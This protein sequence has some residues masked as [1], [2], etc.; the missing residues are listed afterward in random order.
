MAAIFKEEKSKLSLSFLEGCRGF[1]KDALKRKISSLPRV[2]LYGAGPP[3]QGLSIAGKK[4]GIEPC[5]NS[6]DN[7]GVFFDWV[8]TIINAFKLRPT[9]GQ[10]A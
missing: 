5:R 9:P 3:C 4:R 7:G 8:D 2:H 1:G 10:N 6:I